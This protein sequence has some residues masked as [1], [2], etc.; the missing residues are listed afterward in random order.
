MTPPPAPGPPSHLA[1]S[2]TIRIVTNEPPASEVEETPEGAE[3]APS[4]IPLIRLFVGALGAVGLVLGAIVAWRAESST[5]LLIVSALLLVLAA[6]GLDWE[7][8]RGTG[9]GWSF[10][11]VRRRLRDAARRLERMEATEEI[12]PPVRSEIGAIREELEE[13]EEITPPARPRRDTG[14]FEALFRE[15]NTTRAR[16]SFKAGKVQLTFRTPS[17]RD[18]RFECSVTTPSGATYRAVTRRRITLAQIGAPT[19]ATTYPDDFQGSEPLIPGR[20][21]YVWRRTPRA[22]RAASI[23]LALAAAGLQPPLATGWFTIPDP[24]RAAQTPPVAEVHEQ[25]D[26]PQD[27]RPSD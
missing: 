20:Y 25:E 19:Y 23:A 18:A 16:H 22:D 26:D 3:E 8:I 14:D 11:L 2:R 4:A 24:H 12:S 27:A 15:L 21:D 10:E 17:S 1:P 7:E 9:A 5:T 6:L 13:V